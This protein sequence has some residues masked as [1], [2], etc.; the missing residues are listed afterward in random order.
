MPLQKNDPTTETFDNLLRLMFIIGLFTIILVAIL[1]II[2]IFIY[3]FKL[4]TN[5]N[6]TKIET[7]CSSC[8]SENI[9]FLST[10]KHCKTNTFGIIKFNLTTMLIYIAINIMLFIFTIFNVSEG[11]EITNFFFLYSQDLSLI[12]IT[13]IIE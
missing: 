7:K 11:F 2:A 8:K 5:I 1:S 6:Q 10:P 13:N 9:T 4:R 12:E 3:I